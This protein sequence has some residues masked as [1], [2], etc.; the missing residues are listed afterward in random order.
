VL[1]REA[2]A[3]RLVALAPADEILAGADATQRRWL[4]A[5]LGALAAVALAAYALAPLLGR[6][7]L[8]RQQRDRAAR[9]L[10]HL[11]EGVFLVDSNGVIRLWNAAAETITGLSESDASGVPVEAALP[12]WP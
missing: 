7:R 5:S 8:S 2:P 1:T 10:S 9:V 6:S 11:G 3:T 4:L 12:N